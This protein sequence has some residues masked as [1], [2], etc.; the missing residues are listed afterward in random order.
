MFIPIGIPAFIFGPLYLAFEAYL[1]KKD[2]DNV[3]HDAHI[4]GAIFGVIITI[5]F[6]PTLVIRFI[7]QISDFII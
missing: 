5:I 7:E 1:D 3:A 6:K 4:W 2:N